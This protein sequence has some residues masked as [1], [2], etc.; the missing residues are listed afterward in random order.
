M[1]PAFETEAEGIPNVYPS[2]VMNRSPEGLAYVSVRST[3]ASSLVGICHGEGKATVTA[4][5]YNKCSL[6]RYTAH[7]VE[8]V[9]RTIVLLASATC[10]STVGCSGSSFLEHAA[11]LIVPSRLDSNSKRDRCRVTGAED[12]CLQRLDMGP[13]YHVP[14]MFVFH[15]WLTDTLADGEVNRLPES[16]VFVL[17][18]KRTSSMVTL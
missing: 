3:V 13:A 5:E 9:F 15:V 2:E 16:S 17:A 10:S 6:K 8:S 4:S 12:M 11:R 1:D 18:A 14:T 7:S